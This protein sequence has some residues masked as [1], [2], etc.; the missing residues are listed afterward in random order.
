MNKSSNIK[1]T[2][3][4]YISDVI[5][6]HGNRYDY[7]LVDYS[8]VKNKITII[9]KEHGNFYPRAGNFLNGSNCPKCGSNHKSNIKEFIKKATNIHNILYDYSLVEYVNTYIKVKIICLIHGMFEQRPNNHLMGQGCP[10]CG[11]SHIPSKEEI[12]KKSIETHGNLYDY[13]LVE[14]INKKTK[15]KIIC[16]KHGMFEQLHKDHIKGRGCYECAHS[17]PSNTEEFILKSNIIHNNLYNYSSVEYISTHTK[18]SIICKEHGIYEQTPNSHLRGRGCPK[19]KDSKGVT[20]ISNYLDNLDIGFEREVMINGCVS[21]NNIH[22]KYD[23]YIPAKDIYIEYDGE[24]HFRIVE[25]WG[26]KKGFL[27]GKD[28]DKIKDTFCI[29]NNITL[30]RI[31]YNDNIEQ[32]MNNIITS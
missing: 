31:S 2:N 16:K 19:C 25:N 18:V 4:E 3:E 23:F 11:L 12:I 22:L 17:Y 32:M 6:I 27:E 9:C 26:G 5:N 30:H 7:S 29:E 1:K 8:G 15:I 21:K 13:S 24:Q 20:K 10:T 14:Y 28:R